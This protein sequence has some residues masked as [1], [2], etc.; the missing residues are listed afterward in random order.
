MENIEKVIQS[1]NALRGAKFI[2]FVYTAKSTGETARYTLAMGVDYR[3]VCD[4]EIL[5]G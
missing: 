4:R 1:L 5:K 2:S 3:G